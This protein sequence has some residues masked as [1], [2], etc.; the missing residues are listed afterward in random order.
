MKRYKI[1]F[2]AIVF[3]GNFAGTVQAL[4]ALSPGACDTFKEVETSKS[5]TV[6]DQLTLVDANGAE[7]TCNNG[8]VLV[9]KMNTDGTY[10]GVVVMTADEFA[11]AGATETSDTGST[12]TNAGDGTSTASTGTDATASQ[13]NTTAAAGTADGEAQAA[14]GTGAS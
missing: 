11:A 1:V 2:L 10:K 4:E 7:A 5:G 8:D 6:T 3:A 12:A 14:A 13:G 9:V